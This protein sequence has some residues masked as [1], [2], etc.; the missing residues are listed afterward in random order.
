MNDEIKKLLE[1]V[2]NGTV[3]VDE[4]LHHLKTEPF[5]DIGYAKI[6]THRALRKGVGEV[7]YG[8]GKTPGQIFE[9]SKALLGHGQNRVLITRMSEEAAGYYEDSLSKDKEIFFVYDRI[10]KVGIACTSDGKPEFSIPHTASDK[11]HS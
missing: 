11:L 9:I 1:G 5:R 4:A 2:Q 3:S 10:S 8:A 6:D 7:I